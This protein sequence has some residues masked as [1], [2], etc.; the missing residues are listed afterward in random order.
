MGRRGKMLIFKA[1]AVANTD[2]SL[3]LPGQL[4]NGNIGKYPMATVD[5]TCFRCLSTVGEAELID[6]VPLAAETEPAR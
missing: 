1:N 5:G 6:V 2:A 3:S 4:T